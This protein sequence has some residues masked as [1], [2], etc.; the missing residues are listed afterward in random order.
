MKKLF[1]ILLLALLLSNCKDDDHTQPPVAEIYFTG[2]SETDYNGFPITIDTT[3]WTA[4]D[5]W[6][7]Q[8]MNL[9]TSSYQTGC[10]PSSANRVLVYPNPN[11]G[12]FRFIIE[13][14][15]DARTECRIV[16]ENFKV[17]FAHASIIPKSFSFDATKF[18]VKDTIRVYYKIIEN[19][20][21]FR[22]H[23]DI[24]IK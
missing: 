11:N 12:L 21:E 13:K 3:D 6:T 20:C 9:F 4:T 15:L 5:T 16:D 7:R 14:D 8:E 23:G 19:N 22:G 24:L 18:G 2:L 1:S 17:L 10:T